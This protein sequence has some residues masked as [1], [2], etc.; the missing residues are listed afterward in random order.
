VSPYH[1]PSTRQF[2]YAKREKR[3]LRKDDRKSNWRDIIMKT[4]IWTK[5]GPPEGLKLQSRE[6]PIPK[7]DEVLV[8]IHATTVTAGDCEM[9]R[10]ELPLMLSF[11]MRLYAGFTKPKR[12]TTLGQEFAG[13]VE[14]IGKNVKSFQVGDQVFGTTGFRF[15]AYAEYLGLPE[16][17]GDTQG[18][19]SLKPVNLTYEEAAA[20][21]TAGFEALHFVRA[22]GIQPGKKVLI[23]GAAGSI[24]TFAIQLARQ[25]GAEV[26][27]VDSTEKIDLL[28]SLGADHVIDYTK[29]DYIQSGETYDL[30]IDVVGKK[31]VF[32]RL[33]LL[34]PEGYYF[35]AYAGLSDIV[36]SMWVSMRSSKKLKIESSSQN[37]E[38]LLH[39]KTLIEE[40]AIKPVI[41][42]SFPLEQM[43]EAHRFAESGRKKGNIVITVSHTTS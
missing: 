5:Y 14:Q 19:L 40:G 30:I 36:L 18:M 13:E 34:K 3:Y 10:L 26:T 15:G 31:A 28:R 8:K 4:I 43:P 1:D 17:P 6:K 32:Q 25:F 21:P 22:A 11:P 33:K 12:I 7:D 24:G 35:L 39:L 38:D 16:N 29:E 42:R 20:V 9:R 41:D 37:K 23:I 2:L 27:G